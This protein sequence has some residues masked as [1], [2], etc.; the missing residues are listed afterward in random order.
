MVHLCGV[1]KY[2]RTKRLFLQIYD[3]S[4]KLQSVM[5]GSHKTISI[6]IISQIMTTKQLQ[7]DV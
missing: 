4:V 3:H 1:S 6:R 2:P 7:I 5:F